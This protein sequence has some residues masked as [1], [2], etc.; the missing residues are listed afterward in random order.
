LSIPRP[1]DTRNL[2]DEHIAK[3]L[4]A[5]RE[6]AESSITPKNIRKIVQDAM[7]ALG[8]VKVPIGIRAANTISILEDLTQDP[9]MPSYSR[10][11][12]WSAVSALES[13][14]DI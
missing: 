9:N 8:D 6:V 11:T 12:M 14:R 13:V 10:V 7:N 1:Q 2:N 5:L 3:A 4:L